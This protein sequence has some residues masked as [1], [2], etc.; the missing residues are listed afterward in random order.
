[1]P[2]SISHVQATAPNRS[3]RV[4]ALPHI[5]CRYTT[6][7]SRTESYAWRRVVNGSERPQGRRT[8]RSE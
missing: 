2:Q 5:R 8:L 4:G 6:G 3:K 1:M 7:A